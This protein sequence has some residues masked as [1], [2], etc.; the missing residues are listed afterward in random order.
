LDARVFEFDGPQSPSL[1]VLVFVK[2][3]K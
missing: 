3:Y 2:V 1:T